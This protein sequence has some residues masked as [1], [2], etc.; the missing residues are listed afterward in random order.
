MRGSRADPGQLI[1]VVDG[2]S[3]RRAL[4]QGCKRLRGKLLIPEKTDR[5]ILRTR[6]YLPAGAGFAISLAPLHCDQLVLRII[7]PSDVSATVTV[8]PQVHRSLLQDR[9]VVSPLLNAYNLVFGFS[10]EQGALYR[11]R[12]IQYF[13]RVR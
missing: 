3:P 12:L 7:E 6:R 10:L 5:R 4:F 13:R 1:T 9:S 11:D 2:A 8:F